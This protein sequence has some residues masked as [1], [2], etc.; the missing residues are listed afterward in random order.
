MIPSINLQSDSLGLGQLSQSVASLFGKKKDREAQL[1]MAGM[2][3]DLQKT[4]LQNQPQT[5]PT[6]APN[7]MIWYIGGALIIL[8]IIILIARR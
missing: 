3:Y 8:V 7:Y 4:A 2:N 6:T 5:A 1:A